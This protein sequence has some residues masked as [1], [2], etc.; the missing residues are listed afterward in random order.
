[1]KCESA[2]QKIAL[3]V[4]GELPDHEVPALEHHFAG[5]GACRDELEAVRALQQ[6]MTRARREEPSMSLLA[7]ARMKLEEALDTMP[8]SRWL[9]RAAQSI[10]VGLATLGRAPVAASS[11]LALGLIIG[12]F[13]GYHVA[14]GSAHPAAV[15]QAAVQQVGAAG[16]AA[17]I[18]VASVMSIIRDPHSENV[19]VEYDRL[20]PESMRGSLDDPQIRQLLLLGMENG[21]NPGV[22]QNSV[23]L[24][25]EECRAGHACSDGP[26]RRA[27]LVALCYD[28]SPQVRLKAL[29]GLEPYVAE[30]VHVRD[31]VL[32]ALMHDPDSAVRSRAIELLQPVQADSSVQ[33]VLHTVASDDVN[34]HIRTVSREVL[35]QMP[36]IQ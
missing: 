31:S 28:K 21:I 24:L 11:L 32:E 33:E 3:L 7:Q 25:A 9:E 22:Q 6:A 35:D 19:Q 34:P 16:P 4:Y 18:Q 26:I 29:N 8:R 2:Q 5:C 14:E 17:P 1:M 15:Q 13:A 30:D 27:L 36:E 23:S 20:V 12:S 10:R